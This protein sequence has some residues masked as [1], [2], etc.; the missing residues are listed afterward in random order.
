MDGWA[1]GTAAGAVGEGE[2]VAN[3]HEVKALPEAA[4]ADAECDLSGKRCDDR[5]Q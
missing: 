2:L 4:L 1:G 3:K 5:V